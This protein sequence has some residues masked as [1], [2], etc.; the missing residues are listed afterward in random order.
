MT[1]ELEKQFY[2]T[3]EIEPKYIDGCKLND[4][5]FAD[6][7]LQKEYKTLDDY[8]TFECPHQNEY[9]CSTCQYAYDCSEY[10]EITWRK[11]LEMI[12]IMNK[13]IHKHNEYALCPVAGEK[14]EEVKNYMLRLLNFNQPLLEKTFIKEIQQLFKGGIKNV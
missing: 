8:M 9:C 6:E 10:P 5:Y 2:K 14:L 4:K 11:L 7:Q 1:T 3:F 13:H 12:C